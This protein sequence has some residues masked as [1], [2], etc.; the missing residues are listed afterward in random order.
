MC[1]SSRKCCCCFIISSSHFPSLP[2][3][4]S[5]LPPLPPLSLPLSFFFLQLLQFAWWIFWYGVLISYL[6]FFPSFCNF[7]QLSRYPQKFLLG[8]NYQKGRAGALCGG[9]TVATFASPA[10]PWQCLLLSVRGVSGQMPQSHSKAKTTYL[11]Q[12]GQEAIAWMWMVGERPW[13]LPL[14][15][16]SSKPLYF[17]SYS[18]HASPQVPGVA[19]S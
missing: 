12:G 17:S 7:V 9:L 16:L 8:F 3:L 19:N 10:S 1:F 5:F 13:K 18:L 2:Y 6:Y 14:N 15:R 4:L 11:Q